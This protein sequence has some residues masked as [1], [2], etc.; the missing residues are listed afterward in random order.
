[1]KA[2]VREAGTVSLADVP[3]PRLV[4]PDDVI[5]EIAVAG[6]C[7]TDLQVASGAI[8]S[9]EPITL[10]HECCGTVV[11]VGPRAGL[12]IGALATVDPVIRADGDEGFLGVTHHG[13]FAQRVCVPAAN[14]LVLP[15]IDPRAGAYVEPIA[16]ALAV[17]AALAMHHGDRAAIAV[18]GRSRFAELVERVL[19]VEGFAATSITAALEPCSIDVGVETSG[20]TEELAIL[21]EALRPGGLLILKSRHP[22]PVGVPL[23]AIVAKQLVVRGVAYGSFTRAIELVSA[24]ALRLDDLFGDRWPLECWDEAFAAAR[25]GEARKLFLHANGD[26]CAA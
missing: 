22:P 13:V 9:R 18:F 20:T 10:G 17:P 23:A 19:A 8:A 26:P 3:A 7:R 21:I 4:R 25:A 24:R 15:A 1:M 11:E 14:V 16:A 2:L 12:A 5:L 6:I